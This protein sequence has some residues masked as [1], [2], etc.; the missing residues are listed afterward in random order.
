MKMNIRPL[1]DRVIVERI[2]DR[3]T[4]GGIVIPETVSEKPQRGIVRAVGPGKIINNNLQK[5]TVSVGDEVLFGKYSST[6]VQIDGKN[7]LV[8]NEEDI[9]GQII[10]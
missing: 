5:M 4:A 6:D 3:I 9:I 1:N 2:E 10:N 7:L 8:I